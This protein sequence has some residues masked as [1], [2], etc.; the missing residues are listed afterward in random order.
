MSG[1]DHVARLMAHRVREGR[2]DDDEER[3]CSFRLFRVCVIGVFRL[4]CARSV[5]SAVLRRKDISSPPMQPVHFG[6]HAIFEHAL[7]S[8]RRISFVLAVF[9]RVTSCEEEE[10]RLAPAGGGVLARVGRTKIKI[11]GGISSRGILVQAPTGTRNV[12]PSATV[13]CANGARCLAAE[14]SNFTP[15]PAITTRREALMN[16]NRR[17]TQRHFH[18]ALMGRYATH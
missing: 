3:V 17:L 8:F 5:L 13:A 4:V 7:D 2:C 11:H 14:L 10:R 1:V 16:D 18:A 9:E 15:L 12:R 6:S